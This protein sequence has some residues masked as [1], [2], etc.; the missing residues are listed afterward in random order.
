MIRV[1]DLEMASV[2]QPQRY[3]VSCGRPIDWNA[4]ICQ[5]CGHDYRPR[6]KVA[7]SPSRGRSALWI[8]AVVVIAIIIL[9]LV[10]YV[11]VIGFDG[12]TDGTTPVTPILLKSSITGGFEIVFA[13]PTDEVIWSDVIIQLSEGNNEVSWTNITA[14]ALT[15]TTPPKTWHYGGGL[16]LGALSV[17]LN[18]TDLAANGKMN[19]GDYITLTV[20]GGLE[21]SS[22]KIYVLDLLYKP[23]GG[24]M[25]SYSFSGEVDM[26]PS[27]NV[28]QK[29]AVSNGFKVAFTAP[30]SEVA[31]SDV[32]IQLADG[33]NTV[34]WD[35]MTTEGLTSSS[36][37]AVFN[38]AVKTLGT[39]SVY[40]NATDL[41]GNGRMSNGDYITLQVG[42]A[43]FAPSTTYT[44]TLLY[45]PTGGSMLGYNFTG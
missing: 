7:R 38:G 15:G 26:T 28:L 1:G 39:L 20:G 2:Q 17:F 45:E 27:I 3:C 13:A 12:T 25:L 33:S 31:W 10:L 6:T 36:P 18:V 44:L 21:F 29:S 11:W 41:A 23:T 40:M 34:T 37:P 4:D 30:T 24:S 14:G 43:V 32:T 35:T 22:S 42:G 5:Y 16:N 8:V 19:T 9:S